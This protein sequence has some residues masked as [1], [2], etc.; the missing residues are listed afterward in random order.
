M[1]FSGSLKGAVDF[2]GRGALGE[3]G[4]E[5][6]HGD[7]G[8]GNANGHPV[9]F[10]FKLGEHQCN[11]PCSARGCRYHGEGRR[12]RPPEILMGKIEQSLIARI[13]MGGGHEPLFNAEIVQE[14]LTDRGETIGRTGGI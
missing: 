12:S 5:I 11:G 14:H 10:P 13:G 1:S 7:V 2:L 8:C 4:H 6:H 3:L 9:Q